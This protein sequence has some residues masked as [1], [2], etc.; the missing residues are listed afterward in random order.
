L[1]IKVLKARDYLAFFFFFLEKKE[2]KI[3][4]CSSFAKKWLPAR[5]QPKP[6]ATAHSWVARRRDWQPF[7]LT[8]TR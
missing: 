5:S 7:F 6:F 4:G 8:L 2:A 1:Q 3:Q